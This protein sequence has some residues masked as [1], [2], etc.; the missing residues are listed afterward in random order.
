MREELIIM[1][2]YIAKNLIKNSRFK[3]YYLTL[4]EKSQLNVNNRI[5]ELIKIE[6]V[7]CDKGNYD[8]LSN[9]FTALALY[10][11]LKKRGDSEEEACDKV[12]KAMWDYVAKTSAPKMQKTGN[13][14]V[15]LPFMK[16]MLP[17]MLSK[18][19]G[20]GWKYTWHTDTDSK[21]VL[22]FECN[23][24]IYATLLK[25]Y[26]ALNLGK[27]FCHCD[28]INCGNFKHIDFIRTD[29]K[30]ITGKPCNFKFVEYPEEKKFERTK[31]I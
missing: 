30:C 11:E 8:H 18:G 19:S 16:K 20:Y 4:D 25:K 14:K 17:K 2:K 13:L 29:T 1:K 9:L 21:N 26:N 28:V 24:C 12:S 31:S 23:E 22:S 10:E 15:F 6:Q 7:Y 5:S 27:S 3:E